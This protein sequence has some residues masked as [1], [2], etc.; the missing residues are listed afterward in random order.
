LFLTL[1][2]FLVAILAFEHW[3]RIGNLEPSRQKIHRTWLLAL[4]ARGLCSV[5]VGRAI[6]HREKGEKTTAGELPIVGAALSDFQTSGKLAYVSVETWFPRGIT[7]V[8]SRT[9]T[10]PAI[11]A[12]AD[13]HHLKRMDDP[14]AHKKFLPQ[15]RAWKMDETVFPS[16]FSPDDWYYVG[17]LKT[18]HKVVIELVYRKADGKFAAQILGVTGAN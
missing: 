3:S 17:R 4:M 7:S 15:V 13:A 1:N 10:E 12:L 11:L 5:S 14:A 18:M 9:S 2:L 8:F 6:I 16:K